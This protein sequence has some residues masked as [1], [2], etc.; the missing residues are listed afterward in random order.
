MRGASEKIWMKRKEA[1][2]IE[3]CKLKMTPSLSWSL[4]Q[5]AISE[6]NVF[7]FTKY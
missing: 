5:M 2:V 1:M 7:S 6:N 4:M 3:R